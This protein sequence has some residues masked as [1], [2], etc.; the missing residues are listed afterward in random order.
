MTLRGDMERLYAA[1]NHAS[2]GTTHIEAE[3]LEVEATRA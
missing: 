2:D 1:H 3:Y